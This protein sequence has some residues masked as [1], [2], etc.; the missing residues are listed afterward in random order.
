MLGIKHLPDELQK[1]YSKQYCPQYVKY[2]GLST[3]PWVS[4]GLDVQQE[5][6]DATYPEYSI[7]LTGKDAVSDVVSNLKSSVKSIITI[8]YD[9]IQA[10]RQASNWRCAVGKAAVG[11][12]TAF[13]ADHVQKKQ[14]EY[15]LCEARGG[16]AKVAGKKEVKDLIQTVLQEPEL[17][18]LWIK[19]CT[20]DIPS[21]K[22]AGGY[23]V[24][25]FIILYS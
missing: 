4:P 8:K 17:P 19:N 24:V 14:A 16:K 6:L 13:V 15:D 10:K 20:T 9:Y 1:T 3:A 5:I 23:Q 11:V 25:R 22:E 21:S 7:E 2:I 18:F 12:V